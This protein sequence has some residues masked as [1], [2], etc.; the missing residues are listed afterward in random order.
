VS[1]KRRLFDARHVD[2][3]FTRFHAGFKFCRSK[4]N[5][6]VTLDLMW[7]IKRDIVFCSREAATWKIFAQLK[8]YSPTCMQVRLI[9]PDESEQFR[10]V[11]ESSPDVPTTFSRIRKGK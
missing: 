5:F 11:S 7:K 6:C 10:S 3:D 9:L 8:F 1:M 2:E 4:L